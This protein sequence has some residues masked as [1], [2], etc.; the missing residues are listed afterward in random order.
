MDEK[1][2]DPHP[3]NIMGII[4]G[5]ENGEFEDANSPCFIND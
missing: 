5:Y 4:L 1:L 2:I 3:L